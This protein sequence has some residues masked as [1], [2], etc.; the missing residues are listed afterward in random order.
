VRS[1][2]YVVVYDGINLLQLVA[3][4]NSHQSWNNY[5][6][7]S[8]RAI[9]FSVKSREKWGQR[10]RKLTLWRPYAHFVGAIRKTSPPNRMVVGRRKRMRLPYCL[11]E[12]L[13]LQ[14]IVASS[15]VLPM[16]I[17]QVT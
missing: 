4:M 1:P 13:T 12:N 3:T 9:A 6:G 11:I 16:L 7:G 15:R 8:S 5:S 17:Q 14:G 10:G 2:Q